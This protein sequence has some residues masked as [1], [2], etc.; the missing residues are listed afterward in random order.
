MFKKTSNA[1]TNDL[2]SIWAD[3][4]SKYGAEA[5]LNDHRDILSKID[6]ITEGDVPWSVY[7]YR[8]IPEEEITADT[9]SYLRKAHL[10]YY[11]DALALV[12]SILQNTDFDGS[13]DYVP[14][15]EYDEGGKR[16]FHN[17]MSGKWAWE[18]A[19]SCC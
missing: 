12:K 8:G 18:Q 17:L 13:F 3:E 19:V 6:A 7:E 2:L 10:L 11:R 15:I 1:V 16:V 4:A 9:P 14:H 5:P